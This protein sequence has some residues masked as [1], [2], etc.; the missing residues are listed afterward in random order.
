MSDLQGAKQFTSH[1]SRITHHASLAFHL[2]ALGLI[3]W[4]LLQLDQPLHAYMRSLHVLWLERGGDLFYYLGSG[5]GLVTVSALLLAGGYFLKHRRLHR[6]G[7]ESLIAHGAVAL[8]VQITKHLVGRP[9]PRLMR[10][11]EF[12]TGP[13]LESGLDSFPSGHAAASFAVAA[14]VAR[15]FPRWARFAYGVAGLIAVA[16]VVRGSHFAT[17]VAAGVVLGTL[18]GSVVA[19]PL[20]DWRASV[21]G[22][23]TSLAPY[24]AGAFAILWTLCRP[25]ADPDLHGMML[26][27]GSI[28][29]AFGAGSRWGSAFRGEPTAFLPFAMPAIG[30][31]LAL[32]TG[33]WIVMLVVGLVILARRLVDDVSRP[34]GSIRAGSSRALLTEAVLAV[35]LVLTVLSLQVMKGWLVL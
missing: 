9:R 5:G 30:I 8:L 1:T 11:G 27:T 26:W 19:S 22:A 34:E 25:V 2:A 15:H 3:F 35:L 28:A 21:V 24:V 16:R 32:T 14:V 10:D 4:G 7:V 33:A 23:L 20:R 13:S 12:L 6:C 31:G 29:V 17:D 18:V